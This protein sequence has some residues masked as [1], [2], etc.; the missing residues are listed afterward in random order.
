MRANGCIYALNLSF[1]DGGFPFG[2]RYGALL[3]GIIRQNFSRESRVRA[4]GVIH[5]RGK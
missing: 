5:Q 3:M 2:S 4:P 1:C